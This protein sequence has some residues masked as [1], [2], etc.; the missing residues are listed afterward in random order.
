MSAVALGLGT[1]LVIQYRQAVLAVPCDTR[2]L[3]HWSR[4]VFCFVRRGESASP[5]ASHRISSAIATL[6]SPGFGLL[7]LCSFLMF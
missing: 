1:L 6:P 4:G 3:L 7:F 5:G 2:K